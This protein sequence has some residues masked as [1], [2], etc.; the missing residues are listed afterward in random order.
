MSDTEAT[1]QTEQPAPSTEEQ[2]TE[3]PQATE[4]QQPEP[5]ASEP[6]SEQPQE[7]GS[8]EPE[9]AGEEKPAEGEEQPA[10]AEG[11]AKPEGEGEGE[12]AAEEGEKKEGEGEQKEEEEEKKEEKEEEKEEVGLLLQ[13]FTCV[14][15]L[16]SMSLQKRAWFPIKALCY[17]S[18]RFKEAEPDGRLLV[19]LRWFSSSL[20]TLEYQKLASTLANLGCGPY[21]FVHNI[22]SACRIL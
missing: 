8:G 14:A 11:E 17:F 3:T 16:Q 20:L 19:T 18:A 9:A 2:P 15:L 5:Q 10:A 6:A 7:G 4:E 22:D 1:A 13:T 12:Q 21:I